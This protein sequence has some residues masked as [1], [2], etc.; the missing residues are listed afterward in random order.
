MASL[1]QNPSFICGGAFQM[2]NSLFRQVY[3]GRAQGS[4]NVSRDTFIPS[5]KEIITLTMGVEH[6]ILWI[7]YHHTKCAMLFFNKIL[8]K[9]S[10]RKTPTCNPNQLN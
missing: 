7:G 2:L 1:G 4:V 10:I 8:E 3:Q 5:I 6:T 9:K